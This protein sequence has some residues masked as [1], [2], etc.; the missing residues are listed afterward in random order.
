MNELLPSNS[1]IQACLSNS[2]PLVHTTMQ[3]QNST[4]LIP[5]TDHPALVVLVRS[6]ETPEVSVVEEAL[7]RYREFLKQ[8]RAMH[9]QNQKAVTEKPEENPSAGGSER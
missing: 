5:W 4:M 3:Q 8:W 6:S 7:D 9:E 2:T 1:P